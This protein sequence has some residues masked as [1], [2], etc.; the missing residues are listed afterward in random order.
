MCCFR[1]IMQVLSPEISADIEIKGLCTVGTHNS[2]CPAP[3]EEMEYPTTVT[4]SSFGG[5]NAIKFISAKLKKSPE[6]IR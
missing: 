4:Y 6:Y 2:T 1:N 3:C 5:E